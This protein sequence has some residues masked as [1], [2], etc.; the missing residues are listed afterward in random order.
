M[1]SIPY[2]FERISPELPLER[3]S[4]KLILQYQERP[5]YG[6]GPLEGPAGNSQ[7]H[8]A[9]VPGLAV[10]SGAAAAK[11]AKEPAEF[12]QEVRSIR[13]TLASS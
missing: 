8:F 12:S 1:R 13:Y 3:N 7:T 4:H 9:Q 5:V 2:S 10:G 6:E 11:S